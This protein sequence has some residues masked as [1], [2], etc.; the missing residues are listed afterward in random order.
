MSGCERYLK[1]VATSGYA[2]A[3]EPI[4][5]HRFWGRR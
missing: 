1:L 5:P 4:P 3:R 2:I